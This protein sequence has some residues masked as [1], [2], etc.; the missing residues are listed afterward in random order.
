[1]QRSLDRISGTQNHRIFC[2]E[3]LGGAAEAFQCK[4]RPLFVPTESLAQF[5]PKQLQR[6]IGQLFHFLVKGIIL[7][8]LFQMSF[9]LRQLLTMQTIIFPLEVRNH[10]FGCL[11]KQFHSTSVETKPNQNSFQQAQPF[12]LFYIGLIFQPQRQHFCSR[13]VL[14]LPPK[15]VSY[16]LIVG[17][18]VMFLRRQFQQLLLNCCNPVL[19]LQLP[20]QL[21][22]QLH[23]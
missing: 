14:D 2:I 23:N 22:R 7:Q 17:R 12:S 13:Q 1:M 16:A 11:S 5:G 8:C 9:F 19:C 20:I 21:M 18:K 3:P 15:S 4:A 10:C 6:P